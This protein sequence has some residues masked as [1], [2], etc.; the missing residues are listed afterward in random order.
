MRQKILILVK[1][2]PSPSTKYVETVCTAGV[3]EDGTWIRIFPVPFRNYKEYERY[4]KYQW[5]ECSLHKA[6]KDNRPE[7]YHLD[8][9][10]PIKLGE[11]LSSTNH[12]ELRRRA[13]LDKAR[14]FTRKSELLEASRSNSATLALFHPVSVKLKCETAKVEPIDPKKLAAIK[15]QLNQLSFFEDNDWRANFKLAEPIPYDFKYEITDVD[16][17]VF[18]HKIIDWELGALFLKQRAIKG[19]EGARCDVM[20]KYGSVFPNKDK[21]DLYLYMGTMHQFQQRHMP[22][23][24]TIIGVAPFPRVSVRQLDLF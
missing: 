13:I 23:P 10:I 15:A 5:V 22:N 11:E 8:G 2:Y 24:W 19:I 3:R 7:S 17:E 12:W 6:E 1:T 21:I 14:V 4:K 20:D 18:T 16:G 9:D